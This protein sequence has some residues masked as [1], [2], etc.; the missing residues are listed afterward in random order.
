MEEPRWKSALRRFLA[1]LAWAGCMTMAVFS[2]QA[3]SA[4]QKP[5]WIVASGHSFVSGQNDTDSARHRAL[6][7][8]LIAAGL[9][10]GTELAGY[11]AMGMGHIT[12][13]FLIARPTGKILRYEIR[14]A[15]LDRS[16]WTV[17]VRALVGPAP[18][19]GCAPRR[20]LVLSAEPP[21]IN[22]SPQ[23]PAW[24]EQIASEAA[25]DLYDIIRR[26]PAFELERI[27]TSFA[28]SNSPIRADM[29]YLNLTRGTVRSTPGDHLFRPEFRVDAIA[30]GSGYTLQLTADL[31]FTEPSG[32]TLR[33]KIVRTAPMPQGLTMDATL[34]RGR[35]A[36]TTK[37][38]NNLRRD[39]NEALDLVACEPPRARLT[40]D[41]RR[42]TVPIGRKHG[43]RQT[44]LAFI[45]TRD[46]AFDVLEI[47]NLQNGTA[48]LR[49]LDPT[50]PVPSFAGKTV[51][52]LE[53]F[54]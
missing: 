29:S 44:H 9:A 39:M 26:H 18:D 51:E 50:R 22:V 53:G 16:Q 52:F 12:G 35:T 37:L 31:S 27:A 25:K 32:R 11:S 10:G 45:E 36:A 46:S 14:S 2:T 42:L 4:T 30:S 49:P 8:A 15:R 7:E 6:A 38:T 28:P 21:R 17:E 23:A 20:T 1:I 34:G 40:Q 54:R 19:L 24:T 5:L 3:H 13:D 33:R 43:L 48:E 41:G 47:V